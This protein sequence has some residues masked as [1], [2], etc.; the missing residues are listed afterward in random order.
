MGQ[1]SH[2]FS[3][4]LRYGEKQIL[5]HQG[6]KPAGRGTGGE[7]FLHIE[8][9]HRAVLHSRHIVHHHFTSWRGVRF[10]EHLSCFH[11]IDNTSVSPVV[12]SL[13]GQPPFRENTDIVD[14]FPLP[15]NIFSFAKTVGFHLQAVQHSQYLFIPNPRE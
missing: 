1:L 11:H 12:V 15:E 2:Q 5:H 10:A 9:K 14:M 7:Y 6:M 3:V 4:F 8:K 13:N